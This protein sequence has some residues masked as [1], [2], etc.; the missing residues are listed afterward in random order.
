MKPNRDTHGA[1]WAYIDQAAKQVDTWPYWK[2]G[3]CVAEA[4]DR[5]LAEA[6]K[7]QGVATRSK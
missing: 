4:E 5:E 6:Q 3:G 7:V 2:R 1:L